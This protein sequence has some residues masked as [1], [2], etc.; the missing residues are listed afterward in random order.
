MPSLVVVLGVWSSMIGNSGHAH[1]APTRMTQRDVIALTH[2]ITQL[3]I[4]E[5]RKKARG[6]E[7]SSGWEE[8][9]MTTTIK[10][11]DKKNPS[12]KWKKFAQQDGEDT[13]RPDRSWCH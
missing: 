6:D 3:Q 4:R 11:T 7:N 1:F 12:C 8:H 13:R 5:E 9:T 2:L 10:Q